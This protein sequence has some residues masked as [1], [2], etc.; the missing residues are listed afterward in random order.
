MSWRESKQ[1]APVLGPHVTE[2]LRSL[3]DDPEIAWS[4]YAA[5]RLAEILCDAED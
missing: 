5:A 1:S 2:A 3:M 4:A